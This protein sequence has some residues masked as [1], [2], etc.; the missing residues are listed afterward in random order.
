MFIFI[1]GYIDK[2]AFRHEPD[3]NSTSFLEL[4]GD[5]LK[6]LSI[7]CRIPNRTLHSISLKRKLNF[8][9]SY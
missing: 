5:I 2:S 1:V 7:I 9:T 6:K 3:D 4:K 8:H